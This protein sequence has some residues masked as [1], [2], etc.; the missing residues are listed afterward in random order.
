MIA[1]RDLITIALGN[2]WRMK[3][4][5]TLTTL[6]V[7]IAI[8]AFVAMLSFGAGNKRYID[9]QYEDLGLFTT[10]Q[11]YP[12][13]ERDRPDDTGRPPARLDAA[14]VERL[15]GLPGVR[16]AYPFDSIEVTAA[17][18]DTQLTTRA[19]VLPGRARSTRHVAQLLAGSPLARDAEHEA[20][21]SPG[22]LAEAGIDDPQDAIGRR[23]V[24][25]TRV[26]S[27]D[28]ALARVFHG[29]ARHIEEALRDVRLDSLAEPGYQARFLGL[30]EQELNLGL[31]R[32]VDGYLH[33]RRVV[34]DTLVIRGVT[35]RQRDRPLR[36]EPIIIPER[37]AR[38]FAAGD[39]PTDPAELITAVQAGT[40]FE[41]PRPGEGDGHGADGDRPSHRSYPRVTLDLEPDALHGALGDSIEAMG[42]RALSFAEQYEEI[43]RFFLLFNLGLAAVGSIALV[44]AALGIANTMMMAIS[45]RRREIGILESLGADAATIRLLF[46]VESG[47]IGA[48]GAALGTVAGW[49]VARAGS[50]VARLVM[51][52]RGI[53]A[54][55]LFATP[56]WLVAT[57]IL[58]G[59]LVAVTAGALPA[60]RAA[61]IDPVE[62]LRQQ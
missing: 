14:A 35:R 22:F 58:F 49:A 33:A 30:V 60:A 26:A 20:L 45:E 15:A 12:P 55:D 61:R 36:T 56:P 52:R 8:A 42:F 37:T 11:V 34:A 54:I 28:S 39:L 32:F 29:R 2:L 44:T 41:L 48:A 25:A 18:A 59:I 1:T 51:E 50:L 62:A 7:V 10:M 24:V 6:G 19:Q 17:I 40:L 4:R 53:G 46:L 43:G 57:A 21:V 27:L 38:R 13:R 47:L 9:R 5:A 31:A 3:L 16:L 23:L